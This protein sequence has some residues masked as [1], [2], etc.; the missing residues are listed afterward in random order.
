MYIQ[1]YNLDLPGFINL[2]T[3]SIPFWVVTCLLTANI[4]D[5]QQA[6]T[7][8]EQHSAHM[9]RKLEA[10]GGRSFIVGKLRGEGYQFNIYL[11]S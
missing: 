1:L 3:P 8:L 9:D 5:C 6:E 7:Q 11:P 2:S 10:G 4:S